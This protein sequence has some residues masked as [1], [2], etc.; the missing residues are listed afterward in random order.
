MNADRPLAFGR[1]KGRTL[2]ALVNGTPQERGYVEWIAD[3]FE[4][5]IGLLAKALLGRSFDRTIG[6]TIGVYA[7]NTSWLTLK[8]EYDETLAN[9]LKQRIQGLRWHKKSSQWLFPTAQIAYAAE[10]LRQMGPCTLLPDAQAVLE[11][12]LQRRATLSQ[13]RELTDT[14][15]D[16]PTLLPLYPYQRVGV[17]F[18]VAAGGRVMIADAP[19]LGKTSQAIGALLWWQQHGDVTKTLILCP[20]TLKLNWARELERFGGLPATIWRAGGLRK[21]D[22]LHPIWIMNYE[23][24]AKYRAQIEEWAPDLL[25]ADE[26]HYLKNR[27]A[28]RTLAVYGGRP[29]RGKVYPPLDAERV[30]LLSGTPIVNRPGDIFSSL[31]YLAPARFPDWKSFADRY[32]AWPPFSQGPSTPRNLEELHERTKDLIL[33]RRKEEVLTQLPPKRVH[34]LELELDPLAKKQYRKLEGDLDR[35][36]GALPDLATHALLVSFL[37]QQKLPA[38]REMLTEALENDRPCL[39]FSKRLEPLRALKDEYGSAAIYIDGSMSAEARDAEVQRFQRGDAKVAFLSLM[40]AG[41]GITLTQADTVFFLDLDWTPG[42][43]RQAEDRAHRIGQPNPVDVHYLL[44]GN[45]IDTDLWDIIGGK[46]EVISQVVD[47][48]VAKTQSTA[49]VMAQVMAKLRRRLREDA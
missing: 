14:D 18:A 6:F 26:C 25:I 35:E 49:S 22:P 30:I 42:P 3:N 45:T 44:Y 19:G 7:D 4:P 34:V 37:I 13:V 11:A 39:V 41:V 8:F 28:K 16:V 12:E 40:A 31:H 2:R 1:Y 17:H 9:N 20:N 15:F 21:S 43:H 10:A 33:R 24:V 5:P 29:G 27:Q 48:E 46:E 47:G 23:L 32:G 38:L 36:S